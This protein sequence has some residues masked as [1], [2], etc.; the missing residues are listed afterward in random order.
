[1]SLSG[2]FG[3]LSAGR[4]GG[5]GSSAGVDTVFATGDAFDGGDNNVLGLAI[6][7]RYDNMLQYQTPVFAGVQG[8]FQYSFKGDNKDEVQKDLREGS[9][10]R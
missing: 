3:T 5:V 10:G 1:M 9:A 6:S 4:M 8:T 2:D 7:S